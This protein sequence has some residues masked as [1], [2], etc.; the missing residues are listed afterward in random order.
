[1]K[2]IL[3]TVVLMA[4]FMA[5]AQ[6]NLD[7]YKY[8]VVPIRFS[9]FKD[10]NQHRTSTLVK[11]L[12]SQ[13]GFVTVYSDN[14]PEEL[15][16]NRC[17][18]LYVDLIVDS[19]MFTTKT[20]LTLKDCN[21]KEVVQSQQGKSKKKD[22]AGAFSEAITKAFNSFTGLNYSY[23]PKAQEKQEEPI[24][25]SFKNDV[26]IV[27]EKLNQSTQQDAMVVQEATRENQSYQDLRPVASDYKKGEE[28]ENK[29]RVQKATKEE[30][31]FKSNVPIATEYKKGE[32]DLKNSTTDQSI[33]GV[34]YAQ[35]LPN[36]FQLVDS[37]P[38]IQLK[39]YKSSMPNV[40]LAKAD[41]KEGLVYTSDGKW[42][43]EYYN[44][45][46]RVVEELIIKF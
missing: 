8:V 10:E 21:S 42:F 27:D 37:T 46:N 25:V 30:Q 38:K 3:I 36:G 29:T 23:E 28:T 14:L 12:F 5:K 20:T 19:S 26:K 17:M 4:S 22:Y 1:V 2:G 44:D 39:I 41:D 6:F 16:S 35:E 31:S 11:H 40:Y 15:N 13:K 43:F 7:D 32:S 33:L 9:D 34:L 45:G 24:T 18:G